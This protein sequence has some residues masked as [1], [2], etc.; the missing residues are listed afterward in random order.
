MFS[1][2]DAWALAAI[3]FSVLLLAAVLIIAL[4]LCRVRPRRKK[5]PHLIEPP[6]R[7]P[8]E[9]ATANWIQGLRLEEEAQPPISRFTESTI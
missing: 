4:V 5:D 7:D 8:L 1:D 3:I 2:I 9:T 6:T